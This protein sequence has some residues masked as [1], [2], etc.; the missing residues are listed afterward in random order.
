VPA[1]YIVADVAVMGDLLVVKPHY[2]WPGLLIALSAAPVYS[3]MARRRNA[4][5]AA[6]SR[7]A[8]S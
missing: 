5:G 2:T 7:G 6:A 4:T 3:W 1:A 8:V